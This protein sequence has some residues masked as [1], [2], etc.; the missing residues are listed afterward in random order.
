VTVT[1]N[2]ASP[3]GQSNITFIEPGTDATGDFKLFTSTTGLVTSD[4]TNPHT[5][6]RSIKADSGNPDNFAF[7]RK[8]GV[9]ADT[10]RRISFY[11]QYAAAPAA[12]TNILRLLADNE[13]LIAHK[14]GGTISLKS[15]N[16]L[17]LY[18]QTATPS[19][20]PNTW[21]RITLSYTISS[22]TVNEFRLYL[23]GTLVASRTNLKLT[24]SGTNNLQLGWVGSREGVDKVCYLDDIYIDDG[25]DLSDT[26][27]VRVT[28]KLPSGDTSSTFGT[29][30]GANP[31]AGSRF[32][33]VNEQPVNI[34]NGWTSSAAGQSERYVLQSATE[35]DV[36]I[37]PFVQLGYTGWIYAKRNEAW[38]ENMV[39]NGT[40]ATTSLTTSAAIYTQSVSGAAYPSSVDGIGLDASASGVTLYECGVLIAYLFSG[41]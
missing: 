14:A 22:T 3:P 32:T 18:G 9:L 26:G 1:V 15:T 20:A 5:G 7:V 24:T 41:Q 19:L 8:D 17:V 16:K 23:D 33:N 11:F 31:P 36:N 38:A 35:G 28:A 21:Y 2:P 10:G 30:V 27:D 39:L 34:A 13:N 29:A 40:V 37:A 4:V 6:T 25:A 12:T